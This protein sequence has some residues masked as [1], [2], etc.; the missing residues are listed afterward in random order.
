MT[1][2][3][4]I[5]VAELLM[6]SRPT[7]KLTAYHQSQKQVVQMKFCPYMRGGDRRVFFFDQQTRP[8][9]FDK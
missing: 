1:K 4:R 8:R 2:L 5:E 3:G 6:P 9:G 7:G